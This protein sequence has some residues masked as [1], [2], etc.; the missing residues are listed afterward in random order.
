MANSI[1]DS[2][3]R[4]MSEAVLIRH[5]ADV[6]P[7]SQN[8]RRGNLNS[9]NR[10]VCKSATVRS[11]SCRNKDECARCSDGNAKGKVE[12]PGCRRWECERYYSTRCT[13][14]SAR[15]I[16]AQDVHTGVREIS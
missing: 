11:L 14:R 5:W 7:T 1:I 2:V 6:R 4:R 3:Q 8:T 12:G 13:Y 15:D 9:E 16:I 10:S